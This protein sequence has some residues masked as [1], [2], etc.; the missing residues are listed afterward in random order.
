MVETESLKIV[1]IIFTYIIFRI[2]NCAD[3][4]EQQ[5]IV[6]AESNS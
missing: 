2:F 1:N 6:F 4:R 5:A 3:E